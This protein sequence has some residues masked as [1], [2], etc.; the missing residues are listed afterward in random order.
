MGWAEH[1]AGMGERRVLH[2]VFWGKPERRRPPGRH[3]S[4]RENNVR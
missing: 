1:V 4:K 2:K 3:R